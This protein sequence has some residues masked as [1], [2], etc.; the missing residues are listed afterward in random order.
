LG[1]LEPMLKSQFI[2][3]LDVWLIGPVMMYGAW[4]LD[5]EYEKTRAALGVFGALTVWYNWRNYR[6]Y[7]EIEARGQ[8]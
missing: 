6:M 5:P 7:Q 2:R 4:K 1:A 3:Q 8:A